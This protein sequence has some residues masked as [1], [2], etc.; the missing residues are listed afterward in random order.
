MI[1]NSYNQYD[2]NSHT[3]CKN[4]METQLESLKQ[5]SREEQPLG[6]L[7]VHRRDEKNAVEALSTHRGNQNIRSMVPPYFSLAGDFSSFVSN[8]PGFLR[9]REAV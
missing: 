6:P 9:K 2:G 4:T 3:P 5:S 1:I 8:N 7:Q